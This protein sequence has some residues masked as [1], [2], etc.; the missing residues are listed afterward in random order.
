MP[1]RV[2]ITEAGSLVASH[3]MQQ[4]QAAG[5]Q[6]TAV[7]SE[8][9]VEFDS[10][11]QLAEVAG[12]EYAVKMVAAHHADKQ[13]ITRELAD[14][15]CA[16]YLAQSRSDD[17]LLTEDEFTHAEIQ[18]VLTFLQSAALSE[19]LYR[20]VMLSRENSSDDAGIQQVEAAA[21][22][23]MEHNRPDF[24][25]VVIASPLIIGPLFS[26]T[27]QESNSLFVK[28]CENSQ[29]SELPKQCLFADA[30]DIA[31][32]VVE[33]MEQEQANGRYEI[34]GGKMSSMEMVGLMSRCGY[35]VPHRQASSA[36]SIATAGIAA[37]SRSPKT[38]HE[39]GLTCRPLVESVCDTLE[40]LQAHGHLDSR[41]CTAR[42]A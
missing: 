26:A 39:L 16:I 17:S 21:R 41:S 30:R 27:I 37:A 13:A 5:M 14:K 31:R 3:T 8:Q 32:S 7:A 40:S 11:K 20:V 35:D 25:L 24:D 38:Q 22:D 23:Y 34:V 10:S 29:G 33:A 28:L 42:C 1:H 19:R 36:A 2:L 4:M 12:A 9:P 15:D 6:V 18:R